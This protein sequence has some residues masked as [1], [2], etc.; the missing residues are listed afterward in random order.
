MPEPLGPLILPA[1]PPEASSRAQHFS[2]PLRGWMLTVVRWVTEI[3]RAL[4]DTWTKLVANINSI[5]A[6]VATLQGRVT[7]LEARAKD[8]YT[9]TY[10]GTLAVG[11]KVTLPLV[12]RTA[13]TLVEAFANLETVPDGANV[14]LDLHKGSGAG[15]TIFA[16]TKLVVADGAGTG[17]QTGFASPGTVVVGDRLTLDIDQV[18]S[19]EPGQDLTVH[20]VV[21]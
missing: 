16:G 14:I 11:T 3:V 8:I 4:K 19:T 13:G 2:E 21:R 5:I 10:V 18:G 6:D 15:T 12:V 20:L 1:T 9:F 17:T 7:V